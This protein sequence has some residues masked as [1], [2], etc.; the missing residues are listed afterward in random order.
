MRILYLDAASGLSGDMLLGALIDAGVDRKALVG[1]L[2]ALPLTGF[3]VTARPVTRRHIGALGVTVT[4]PRRQPHRGWREIRGILARAGLD[5]AVKEASLAVFRR[6]IEAEAGVHRIPVERVHLHEVGAVDAIVDVVG[7]AI[8][9]QALG[10]LGGG[11]LI[12]S[13]LNVG[14]GTVAMEHGTLP[15]PAP[16]TAALL[17]GAPIYSAGPPMERVTPTGAAIVSTLAHSFGPPPAMV[18]ERIG[19][20]AGRLDDQEIPN[21]LRALVG[22][23]WPGSG[24]GAGEVLVLESTIDDMNPQIYGHAMERLFAAGALEVFHTPVQMKKD[25]PGVLVTVIAP[26]A[27][28]SELS[29]VL[30]EETTTLGVRY[31]ACGRLEL[32]RRTAT[33]ATPFGRVRVKV[34]SLDGRV[35]QAQPEYEDCR[36]LASRRGV[37]LKDVQAAAISSYRGGA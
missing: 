33:V 37:P 34:A 11:R 12:C 22:G 23:P 3:R 1:S 36:R 19:H 6:L 10:I 28:L 24:G 20:G 27:R 35:M 9:L 7:S 14:S 5:P 25:R 16:A 30:F 17:R 31:R 18:I 15:V 21:I 13:P 2:S 4:A 32:A 26:P 29:R 8:G